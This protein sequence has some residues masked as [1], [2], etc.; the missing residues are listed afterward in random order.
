[1]TPFPDPRVAQRDKGEKNI[2][3][4]S[5]QQGFYQAIQRSHADP[6]QV[7]RDNAETQARLDRE[8]HLALM[9][10]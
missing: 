5:K 9:D 2:P 8:G 1:M 4:N 10:T 6:R 7:F 3:I